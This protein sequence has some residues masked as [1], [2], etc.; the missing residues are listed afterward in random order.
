MNG[1]KA[2]NSEN[3]SK[4]DNFNDAVAVYFPSLIRK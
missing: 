3:I 2:M 1:F 4:F